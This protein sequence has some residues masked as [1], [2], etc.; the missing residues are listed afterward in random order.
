[1]QILFQHIYNNIIKMIKKS[2][3]ILGYINIFIIHSYDYKIF[4]NE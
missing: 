2:W 4:L 3:F 1:M